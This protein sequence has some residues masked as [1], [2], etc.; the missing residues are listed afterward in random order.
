MNRGA[1]CH[2]ANQVERD[3]ERGCYNTKS[4]GS[5]R[6]QSFGISLLAGRQQPYGNLIDIQDVC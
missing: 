2:G 4:P 1:S 5:E 6:P 3:R